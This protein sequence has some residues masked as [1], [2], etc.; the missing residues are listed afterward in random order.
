MNDVVIVSAVRTA[1]G[2]FQGGLSSFTATELG[3]LVIVEAIKRAGIG[4]EL[5]DEVIMGNVVPIGLGQNPGRQAMIKAGLPMAGGAITVNKVCGSGLKAVML[6]EQAIKCG[7]ADIIAA[8]GMES[9]S[10]IPH[11]LPVSRQGMRMGDWKLVDGMVHDGLWDVVNDYHMGYTAELVSEKFGISREEMDQ[12]SIDSNDKALAAQAAGKFKAEIM[13]VTIKPRK[14]DPYVVDTDEGPR[15]TTLANLEKLRPAFKKDGLV[16]AGNAS[17]ISDGASC[18]LVMSG[19]KAAALGLKPLARIVA[20]G[21]AGVPLE[22][23]LVAPINSIPKVLQRAGMKLEEI[24]IHEINEAFATSSVAIVKE[25]GID[26][27]RVNVHGG[28]VALGHPIGCSGTRVLTTLIY[29]MKD[30][31]ARFGMASLCLGGGEAVSMIIENI[32]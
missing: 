19:E 5:V 6:A 11:Y 21:A 2:N 23:V 15:K 10:T 13:P 17:K 22:D 12:F 29:A 25:L 14:G 28:A 1:I 16:T 32:S 9:M 30:R 7:D 8:G 4:K 27:A 26:M 31:D 18:T 3:A 24:D 20:Q